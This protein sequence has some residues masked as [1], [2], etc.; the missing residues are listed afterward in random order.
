MKSGG[1]K[2]ISSVIPSFQAVCGDP[3][4]FVSTLNSGDC[5]NIFEVLRTSGTM[6]DQTIM[7]VDDDF[8][9]RDFY[10]SRL[11]EQGIRSEDFAHAGP[12]LD[13]LVTRQYDLILLEPKIAPGIDVTDSQLREVWSKARPN[14]EYWRV[15]LH[16][17]ERAHADGSPNRRT[18]VVALSVYAPEMD[19][20]FPHARQRT[21]E[22][23]AS[24]Y[25][26]KMEGYHTVIRAV[27]D[28][29]R[30]GK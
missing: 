16:L 11:A 30:R 24:Q 4:R 25:F 1:F 17:I 9:T 21:M 2:K 20:L 23:G 14:S 3:A 27:Q 22:A 29:L 8:P 10:R 7:H 5:R 6:M 15:G 13:A 12:A 28:S 26:H 19:G 18:P